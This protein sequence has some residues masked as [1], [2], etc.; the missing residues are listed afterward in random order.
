VPEVQSVEGGSQ[1][2]ER[3]L[4]AHSKLRYIAETLVNLGGPLPLHIISRR[5]CH[6]VLLAQLVEARVLK[7][8]R[9]AKRVRMS[10]R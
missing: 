8:D 6:V 1:F 7:A 9:G 4:F 2:N 10:C 5:A 3:I